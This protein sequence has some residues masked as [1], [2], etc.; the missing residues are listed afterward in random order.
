MY[1]ETR[2]PL[3]DTEL[4]KFWKEIYIAATRAG[5]SPASAINAADTAVWNLVHRSKPE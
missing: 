3:Q 2:P 5:A 1:S 4:R